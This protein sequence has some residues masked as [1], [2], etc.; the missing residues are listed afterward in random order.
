MAQRNIGTAFEHFYCYCD[1][2]K[3]VQCGFPWEK[4]TQTTFAPAYTHSE[5]APAITPGRFEPLIFLCSAERYLRGMPNVF[6]A[7][8]IKGKNGFRLVKYF[9]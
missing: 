7:Y 6:V 5:N 9:S 8:L 4:I 2:A 1:P 3:I